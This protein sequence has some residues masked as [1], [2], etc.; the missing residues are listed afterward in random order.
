[1]VRDDVGI[2][3]YRHGVE[4][5]IVVKRLKT[6]GQRCKGKN[7]PSAHDSLLKAWFILSDWREKLK[8]KSKS[9]FMMPLTSKI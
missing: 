5:A 2:I 9:A 6:T 7:D 1:M 3:R 4:V 8:K